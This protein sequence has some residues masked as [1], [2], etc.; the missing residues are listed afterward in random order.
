M[1]GPERAH[2][3]CQCGFRAYLPPDWQ[4]EMGLT[5]EQATAKGLLAL[6]KVTRSFAKKPNKERKQ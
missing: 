4:D 2:V 3:R 1:R 6:T 5:P